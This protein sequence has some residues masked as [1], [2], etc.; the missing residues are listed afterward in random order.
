[1]FSGKDI[2][3]NDMQLDF[4]KFHGLIPAV[5]QDVSDGE[6]LMVG[7]MNQE[8]FD[9]TVETGKVTFFSRTRDKLW[10]KGA[11]SGHYLSAKEIRVDCDEDTLVIKAEAL[12]PGVCHNGF[13]SCFYRRFADGEWMQC[14]E[15]AYDPGT[16]YK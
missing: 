12:G 9:K 15:R 7:F 1:M 14:A 16:V 6:V 10:T 13:R 4:S 11:T 8:A 3:N 5:I 2:A